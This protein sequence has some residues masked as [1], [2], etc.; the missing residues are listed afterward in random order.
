VLVERSAKIVNTLGITDSVKYNK[1][2]YELVNQYEQLNLIHD[3]SKA[4][5]ADIKKQTLSDDEKAAA[6]KTQEEKNLQNF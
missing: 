4:N 2:V 1:V 5:I 6:I 3:Q